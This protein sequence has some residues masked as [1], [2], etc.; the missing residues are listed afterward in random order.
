MALPP[1]AIGH[2]IIALGGGR[3]TTDDVVDPAVGVVMRVRVGDEVRAG[4]PLATV[5]A[6]SASALHAGQERM[7]RVI[8]VGDG[9]PETGVLP[10]VSHRVTAAGV[11]ECRR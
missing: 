2:A 10:W 6:S 1:R 4:Q 7:R 5:H 11:E 3:T 9:P 8:Q